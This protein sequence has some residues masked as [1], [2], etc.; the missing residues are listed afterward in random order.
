[1]PSSGVILYGDSAA[2]LSTTNKVLDMVVPT[3][4]NLT[5]VPPGYNAVDLIQNPLK[6]LMVSAGWVS[7]GEGPELSNSYTLRKALSTSF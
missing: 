3:C 5:E 2:V 4:Y 1:M 6:N 7:D